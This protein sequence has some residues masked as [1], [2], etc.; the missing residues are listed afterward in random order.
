MFLTAVRLLSIKDLKA[1]SFFLSA[2]F[3]RH[4]GPKGP[5]EKGAC[6]RAVATACP[7]RYDKNAQVTV[8]RGPVPRDRCMA[9]FACSLLLRRFQAKALALRYWGAVFFTVARGL[10]PAFSPPLGPLGP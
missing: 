10:S 9:R 8:A 1:L 4:A 3:Y 2:F 5:E 6:G 7:A